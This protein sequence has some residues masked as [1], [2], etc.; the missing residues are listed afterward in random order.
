[1]RALVLALT[2]IATQTA[3]D[4]YSTGYAD[5]KVVPPGAVIA[6][7]GAGCPPGVTA[8]YV[9]HTL[10]CHVPAAGSHV[11][12]YMPSGPHHHVGQVVMVSP[13]GHGQHYGYHGVSK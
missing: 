13:Y 5:P 3:A 6:T 11:H 4:G 7:R 12:Y 10:Y 9:G 2:L 1:M 8:V